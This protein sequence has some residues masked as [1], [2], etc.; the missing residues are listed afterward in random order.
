MIRTVIE[1]THERGNRINM[2]GV[3]CYLLIKGPME[4]CVV[5]DVVSHA[6]AASLKERAAQGFRQIYLPFL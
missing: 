4:K 1:T 2:D 6:A 3:L 5:R